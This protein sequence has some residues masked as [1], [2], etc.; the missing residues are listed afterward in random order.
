[1][2]TPRKWFKKN[3]SGRVICSCGREMIRNAYVRLRYQHAER[4]VEETC[5]VV[6]DLLGV[7]VG[8]VM[9]VKKEVKEND[10]DVATPS[11]KRPR[12]VGKRRRTEVYDDFTKCALRSCVH[13]FF[14]RNEIPTVKKIAADFNANGD[15]TPLNQWT[16][17]R[18]L[19]DIGFRSEKRGRDSRLIERDDIV[20]WQQ[21]YLH[22]ISSYRKDGRKIFFLD[23]T[24]VTAGHT[25][26]TVWVDTTVV[27]HRDAFM[28]GLTTG[29]KQPSGKGQRLIVTHIGSEDGFVEG[30]LDVFRGKKTG[31]YHEEMDGN[32]FE[33]WFHTVLEKLPQGSVIVMDNASYHSRLEEAVP[34]TASRKEAVQDWLTSKQIVW[35]PKMLKKELLNI[36]ASV[37]PRYVRYRVDSAA[38]R[39]GCIV[40][41][42][43]P[44]HCEL[45]PIELIWAQMKRGV[46]ARNATF[47]L[48]D[49]EALLIE[50]AAK[51]TTE[52]WAKAVKHVINIEKKFMGDGSGSAYVQ[53]I[54][55]NLEDDMDS[56]SD[57]S[58]VEPLEDL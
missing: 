29:L 16:V 47:K 28:R 22:D 46:A 23:E 54:I 35:Q 2:S 52:H 6:S 53:P 14:R 18:L 48:T 13:R 51:V 7:S 44:Y 19:H 20:A 27:S 58:G 55:I 42:L 49:V 12:S 11:R 38:E 56:E 8:L 30:C 33:R 50:E 41:R 15:V 43:P 17:R 1:M 3:K 4:S 32:R 5:A 25:L 31:D 45:N 10:G 40:L 24:W 39:A 57:V 21:R 37:K 34:T 36:V 9:E 26:S